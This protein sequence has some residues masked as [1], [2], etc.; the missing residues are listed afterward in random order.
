[1]TDTPK[2]PRGRPLAGAQRH[3]RLD[4]SMAPDLAAYARAQPEGASRYIA[5]LIAADICR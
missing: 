1:M 2:R 3:V 5:K 4:A